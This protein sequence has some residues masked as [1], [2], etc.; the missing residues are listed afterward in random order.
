MNFLRNSHSCC[1]ENAWVTSMNFRAPATNDDFQAGPDYELHALPALVALL[2]PHTFKFFSSMSSWLLSSSSLSSQNYF[3]KISLR[4]SVVSSRKSSFCCDVM[5]CIQMS[6]ASE[7]RKQECFNLVF[8]KQL[9]FFFRSEH[10]LLVRSRRYHQKYIGCQVI[11]GKNNTY[12]TLFYINFLLCLP[13]PDYVLISKFTVMLQMQSHDI[14]YF[15]KKRFINGLGIVS[16]K[17]LNFVYANLTQAS[18]Y[19]AYLLKVMQNKG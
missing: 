3:M 5:Q 15:C 16:N 17:H 10:W 6:R 9:Q 2:L 4:S 11:M 13:L 19:R 14:Y 1:V 18:P 12:S 7:P 8:V